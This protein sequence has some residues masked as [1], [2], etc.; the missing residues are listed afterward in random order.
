MGVHA[1]EE[2]PG[3]PLAR[4]VFADR[5]GD[6]QDVIL[7]EAVAERRAA[8][9]RGAEGHGV[10]RLGRVGMVGV[11]RGDE[12]RDVDQQVARGGFA[13]EGMSGHKDLL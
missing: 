2:R 4:A 13:G 12:P 7:V 11:V 3:R 6:R 1:D 8:V 9:P 5:L 10:R